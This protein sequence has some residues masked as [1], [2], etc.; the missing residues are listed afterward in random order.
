[1]QQAESQQPESLKTS[2]STETDS[3][4]LFRSQ[5]RAW[6]IE[7]PAAANPSEIAR[8]YEAK[9]ADLDAVRM[10]RT[11][12][13]EEI[14]KASE[15]V[16]SKGNS[17]T[18]PSEA[19]LISNIADRRRYESER[20]FRTANCPLRHVEDLDKIDEAQNAAWIA[21]RDLLVAQAGYAAG[22]MV[23]LIG[24]RGTGKTQLAVSVIHRCCAVGINCAYVK[25]MDLFKD[26][27][28]AYS[29]AAVRG[30]REVDIIEKWSKVTLLVIDEAHQRAET[31]WEQNTLTNLLDLRY[32]ARKCTILIAN[33]TKE[34]FSASMGDSIISRMIETGQAIECNWP[35]YR[36][37]GSW[38]QP[39]GST[40][41]QRANWGPRE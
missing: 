25:V 13:V 39:E 17:I 16:L 24:V 10:Q 4:P 2:S 18:L 34:E 15:V 23:A 1:M 12:A 32:D 9:R 40:P 26:M 19:R 21:K 37:A 33:Q 5:L 14:T 6:G 8:A 3:T 29:P 22:F 30:E 38:I 20:L 11:A 28:R 41:R 36:K 35:T 27:R 7:L 31:A